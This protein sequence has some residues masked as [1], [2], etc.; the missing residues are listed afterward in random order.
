MSKS[1]MMLGPPLKFSRIF[2]S[3]L[4]FF[5]FTGWI[6]KTENCNTDIFEVILPTWNTKATIHF[7]CMEMQ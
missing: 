1:V 2:I 3:R 5:F 6:N 4:I 7:H